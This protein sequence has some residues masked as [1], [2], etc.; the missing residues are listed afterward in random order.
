M[1]QKIVINIEK[2][3]DRII[4]ND[5]QKTNQEIEKEIIDVFEKVLKSAEDAAFVYTIGDAKR[6][7]KQQIIE[8]TKELNELLFKAEKI[9]LGFEILPINKAENL[10][11]FINIEVGKIEL[12]NQA[13]HT[14]LQSPRKSLKNYICFLDSLLDDE[15]Y[16]LCP[17]SAYL[18]ELKKHQNHNTKSNFSHSKCQNF[19]KGKLRC[20][21]CGFQTRQ[22]FLTPDLE[23]RNEFL[24]RL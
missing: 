16:I 14:N 2:M 22:P 4:I 13:A 20:C 9:G 3:V 15:G 11:R 6:E 18:D 7:T 12:E 21:L 10:K 5:S 19:H 1:S 24:K 23:Y 8:K 17:S